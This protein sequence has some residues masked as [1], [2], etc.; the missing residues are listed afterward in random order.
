[1]NNF[2][3]ILIV[4]FF[5]SLAIHL[6]L[7]IIIN[8]NLQNST[9]NINTTD[10]KKTST[11]SHLVKIKYLKVKKNEEKQKE[12]TKATT[13]PKKTLTK[14][15]IK[16]SIPIIKKER[17]DLKKF[18][19]MKEEEQIKRKNDIEIA[20]KLQEEME[21]IKKLPLLTQ[22]Y[23][24]LYGEKYFQYSENQRKYLRENLNKIGQITQKYLRYPNISIRTKQKGIN[25]VEF[26]LH[27]NGDITNI[28]LSDSSYYTAL[29]NNTIRTIKIAYQDYPKPSEKVK[30]KIF[31]KYIL[32]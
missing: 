10:Q 5:I 18:F 13:I 24:K 30:I 2:F 6:T 16:K 14:K 1:M 31:V 32:Y 20:Y 29:D 17:L 27:P 26:Y 3:K 8:K 21:E 23:I 22:S 15:S 19:V 12:V 7:Y 11:K 4:A 28:K 25:V 9:L